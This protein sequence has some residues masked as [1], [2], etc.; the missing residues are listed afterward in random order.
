MKL[1][2]PLVKAFGYRLAATKR[3]FFFSPNAIADDLKRVIN[4]N[5]LCVLSSETCIPAAS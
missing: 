3:L 5:A 2:S 4:V 1:T